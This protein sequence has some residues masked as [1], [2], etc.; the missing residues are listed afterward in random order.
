[1]SKLKFDIAV[2]DAEAAARDQEYHLNVFPIAGQDYAAVRPVEGAFLLMVKLAH[3]IKSDDADK[4]VGVI[5]FLDMCL[6]PD[7][8]TAALVESGQ[9]KPGKDDPDDA[10]LNEQGERLADSND[11]LYN[12]LMDRSDP[13]GPHTLVDVMLGL[14]EEWS[15][16][17]TGSPQDFLPGRKRTGATSTGSSSRKASTSRKSTAAPR[18]ASSARST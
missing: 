17:P 13:L 8:L 7:D 9:Y 15:G 1:M 16:N 10:V 2:A 14:V 6:D 5:Q 11:R 3:G 12:R 4:M 18:R